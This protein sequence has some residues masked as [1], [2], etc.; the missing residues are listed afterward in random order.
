MAA[1]SGSPLTPAVADRVCLWNGKKYSEGAVVCDGGRE[2]ECAQFASGMRW[3]NTGR[4][5][6]RRRP[7]RRKVGSL[8]PAGAAVR[9]VDR[10]F[11]HPCITI[12]NAARF[13]EQTYPA[14]QK[15]VEKL[16]AAG[17]LQERA[18]TSN[19]K[20]FVTGEIVRLLDEPLS[21]SPTRR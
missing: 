8:T 15:N 3:W 10:L 12:P 11:T 14:A 18:G 20:V 9:R 1:A 4:T 19:P 6:L 2:Y 17:I 5:C 13:L 21:D 7:C 16:V